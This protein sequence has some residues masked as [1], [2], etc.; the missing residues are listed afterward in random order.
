[1]TDLVALFVPV[2]GS[3]TFVESSHVV[4]KTARRH[5]TQKD[6]AMPRGVESPR[7]VTPCRE[8]ARC[9][10]VQRDLAQLRRTEGPRTSRRTEGPL[11]ATCCGETAR[12][13]M[14]QRNRATSR[15]TETARRYSVQI[16]RAT[17]RDAKGPRDATACK[18]PC[19]ATWCRET[20]RR[21]VVQRKRDATAC[22]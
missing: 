14:M 18:G 12:C 20:V 7:D 11:D 4:Q 15:R 19:D 1:M 5:V 22:R 17:L 13:H 8:T 10:V 2:H 6:R 21:H 16:S 3:W 9:Y